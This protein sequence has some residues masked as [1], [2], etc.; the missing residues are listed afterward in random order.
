MGRQP[1]LFVAIA[2]VPGGGFTLLLLLNGTL[3]LLV[4]SVLL[5]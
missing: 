4:P 2:R 5:R 3:L 1:L